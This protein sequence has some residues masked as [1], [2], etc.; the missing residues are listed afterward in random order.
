MADRRAEDQT[1]PK[2]NRPGAFIRVFG[3][4]VFVTHPAPAS[5][6]RTIGRAEECDIVVNEHSVSRIH[7]TLHFGES[8]SIEDAGSSNGTRVGGIEL[9]A[10]Q[11][12][13]LAPG[14]VAE[15]GSVLVM[16]DTGTA[17]KVPP[18]RLWE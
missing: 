18:R 13:P 10:G 16:I 8:I 7:A 5:G 11:R 15:L 4:H 17:A 1:A 9:R 14:Q 6:S 3:E 2:R 12:A